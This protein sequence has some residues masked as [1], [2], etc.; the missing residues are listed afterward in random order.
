MNCRSFSGGPNSNE[1]GKEPASFSIQNLS[2][3][4][5]SLSIVMSLTTSLPHTSQPG[6]D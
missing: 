2:H 6:G 1:A 3:G 5:T 4:E